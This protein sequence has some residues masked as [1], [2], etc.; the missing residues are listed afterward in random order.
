MVDAPGDRRA[1]LRDRR[2]R[3]HRVAA[4]TRAATCRFCARGDE[5]LCVAPRFTGWDADG[6]YAEL[7]VVDERYAYAIPD[8]FDDEHAA[9]LLCAGIIGYR[10]LRRAQLPARRAAR[11]LRLRRLGAPRRA[12]RDARGRDRARVHPIA[13]AAAARARARRGIGRRHDRPAARA[14]RRRRSCSR[15][16]ATLVPV[17]LD[18]LDSGGTLADRRASTSA[19]SRRS[20]TSGTCSGAQRSAASPPTPAATARSSSRSRRASP[21]G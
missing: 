19:T 20:R 3:R 21:S 12:G 15:R 8:A 9:P 18:A 16:S 7:A 10:A 2:P 6:G 17:A 11:D 14:A 4:L 1:A 13:E 5:N